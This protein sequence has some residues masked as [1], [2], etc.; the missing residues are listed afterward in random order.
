MNSCRSS[1][2]FCNPRG[3]F[4]VLAGHLKELGK[5]IVHSLA[6]LSCAGAAN[7]AAAAVTIT[8]AVVMLYIGSF[9]RSP[10]RRVRAARAVRSVPACKATVVLENWAG[11]S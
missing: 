2:L 6:K 4:D 9:I 5:E 7:A 11:A 1:R 8:G 10:R 3:H